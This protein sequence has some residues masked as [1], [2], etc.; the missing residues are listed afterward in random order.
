[1]K[2]RGNPAEGEV[3]PLAEVEMCPKSS[4]E[5]VEKRVHCNE[6]GWKRTRNQQ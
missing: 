3:R 2:K 1:M 6:Y 4:G 5:K